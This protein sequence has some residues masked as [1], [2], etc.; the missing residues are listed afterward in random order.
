MKCIVSCLLLF[1]LFNGSAHCQSSDKTNKALNGVVKEMYCCSYYYMLISAYFDKTKDEV[2]S[3][4]SMNE[5]IETAKQA[6]QID[7]NGISSQAIK[8]CSSEINPAL[9][10]VDGLKVLMNK[11]AASCKSLRSHPEKRFS[12]LEL[13]Y[14]IK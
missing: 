5:S 9:N 6:N 2:M 8:E 1:L 10:Q 12:E 11:Y 13:L 3:S 14:S 4:R 7:F